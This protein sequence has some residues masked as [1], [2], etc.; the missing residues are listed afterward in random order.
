MANMHGNTWQH[1]RLEGALFSSD[2]L[3]EIAEDTALAQK[4]SDYH[5]NGGLS[6]GDSIGSAYQNA[7]RMKDVFKAREANPTYD[8]R[9]ATVDF[10][11]GV[12]RSCLDWNVFSSV[13]SELG[14]PIQRKAFEIVPLTINPYDVGLDQHVDGENGRRKSVFQML[15]EY[16]DV[17]G[18]EEWGVVSNG[19]SVR[20]LRSSPTLTRPQ[21]LEFDLISI[22]SEDN[23]AE[24]SI[25]WKIM[26]SSRF[27]DR[28]NSS[29]M[30]IWE[31][32]R[33]TVITGGER[34]REGLRIGVQH[35][36]LLWGTG[37]LSE[38]GNDGLR[39]AFLGGKI[40]AR[41]YFHELLRLA[42][43][44]LF[45]F[46]TE[47]R[48]AGNGIR[49]LFLQ[50]DGLAKERDLYDRGYSLA[51]LRPLLSG[52][53]ERNAFTDLWETQKV[54]FRSLA[55]G[56]RRLALPALGGLFSAETCP[57]LMQASMSN[58]VF[59]TALESLRWMQKDG[60]FSWIDYKNMG[61]E[62]L[63]SVYES[64]LELVPVV[65]MATNTFRFIGVEDE[66]GTN[67]GNARKTS[68]S[69]YTPHFLV[70][71]LLSTTLK[72]EIEK[73]LAENKTDGERINSLLS[74]T[75][76]D[77]ACGSGHFLIS[78]AQAIAVQISHL[79]PGGDS[80]DGYRNALRDVIRHCIYGVDLNPMAV[81]LT[82]MALWL[83]S[84]EPG[85]PL[86][87]LDSHIR[88]GNSL[89]GVFDLSILDK[90]IPKDAYEASTGDDKAFCKDL[91]AQNKKGLKNLDS[92]KWQS[93][94]GD[95]FE[96][97][98]SASVKID[99]DLLPEETLDEVTDK[100]VKFAAIEKEEKTSDDSVSADVYIG[101]FLLRKIPGTPVPTTDTLNRL[102]NHY[103]YVDGDEIAIRN[104]CAK[105][106]DNRAFHWKLEF[107]KVFA[108]GGFDIVLGNPPWDKIKLQEKEFFAS[109]NPEIANAQ[110]ASKREK[111]INKLSGGN[112]LEKQLYRE[113]VAEL[114][115][116]ERLS[117]FVHLLAS[118][119]GQ[120]PLSGTGDVNMYALFAELF[121]KIKAKE[122][123]VGTVI[124]SGISTD[125]NTQALFSSFVNGG[126]LSSLYDF[127]NHGI[128]PAVHNS[129]K[130]SL[131]TLGPSKQADFACF[132]HGI[133]E[134]DDDRR[135]FQLSDD[136][137]DLFNPNTH[138][139]SMFRSKKDAE[140]VLKMYHHAKV[141]IRQK[142]ENREEDNPWKVSFGTLFH[143][144]NDS[145]LFK[146]HDD[147]HCYP[148]YEAKMMHQYDHRWASYNGRRDDK[149]NPKPDDV[150][151]EK[152]RNPNYEVTP[153]YWIEKREV[154]NKLSDVPK[155]IK[156]VWYTKD[157]SA[158]RGLLPT[159]DD[160]ELVQISNERD[161]LQAM[162]F[163]M[164][165]RCPKYLMGWRDITNSTN[166]RTTI[167]TI[168]PLCGTN[169]HFF[170]MNCKYS[171]LLLANMNSLVFDYIT[172]NKMG[173][174]DLNYFYMRQLCFIPPLSYSADQ[175]NWL[176]FHVD[177]LLATSN[178]MA[179]A[180][181][182]PVHVFDP[183]ERA[184]LRADLDA[185][186]ARKYGLDRQDLAYILDPADVMGKDWP[187]ITFPGL[188]DSEI[189]EF[190]EYR[191]KRLVL[192]AWDRQESEDGPWR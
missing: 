20:L 59:L 101:A 21:F 46:A 187:S 28:D 116:F 75:V 107:R 19:Y 61:T 92:L 16:L 112:E 182:C 114:H 137:F 185:F 104:A 39:M 48:T 135:H 8:K 139:L 164:E 155:T 65:D 124:P 44:F 35:A 181:D 183:D 140:L 56:E 172:R 71:Q 76:V 188:R 113:Y 98:K 161:I 127:E 63:G 64:L 145:S 52:T 45:L 167:A 130:F 189:K 31:E 126:K 152:K 133:Q 34:V 97:G 87:F 186:Y 32:W 129:Y 15:Q 111:L 174:T 37:F 60:R 169:N 109:R 106:R 115:G 170:L 66:D 121:T 47:E 89:L 190:G 53:S 151:D 157:V 132:L 62:E 78:A 24:F 163:I 72:P 12:F 26:H 9:K 25:F 41:G 154:W 147:G 168:L 68:G 141:L 27:W 54:V 105:S 138:T 93:D 84:F 73:R 18:K 175:Q 77:P 191:T 74:L 29:R 134:L 142:S 108:K 160:S 1:I 17:K 22:L 179:E 136:D 80:P 117:L 158:L 6:I 131:L 90:G 51:R 57:D 14:Y 184:L 2:L 42:Y 192:E 50:D 180:L 7:L 110:N 38:K 83:E 119:D 176:T 30:T 120:Y 153:Q 143:M 144:S 166:Q 33:T 125:D 5:T 49:L 67:A 102:R 81:E 79:Q 85:K 91:A 43:R 69:Y 86:G 55:N 122:G 103:P 40:D 88:T 123:R 11:T 150:P 162:D 23:Y 128:F 36:L 156:D 13:R 165:K 96:E 148:L 3:K 10:V 178:K 173:G 82:K 118:D 4:A 171:K 70:E 177:Q 95:L 149:G 94:Q 100:K 159:C 99:L 58:E 146:D